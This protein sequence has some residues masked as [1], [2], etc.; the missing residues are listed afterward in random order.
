MLPRF[1]SKPRKIT[2]DNGTAL[3]LASLAGLSFTNGFGDGVATAIDACSAALEHY[4]Q[5]STPLEHADIL[6]DLAFA[7]VT[8]AEVK[9]KEECC[10]TALKIYRRANKI[11]ISAADRLEED[12]D[13]RAALHEHTFPELK[14]YCLKNGAGFRPIDLR[15]GISEEAS[16]DQRT[17]S[18]CLSELRRCQRISPRPNFNL[19]L[20]GFRAGRPMVMAQAREFLRSAGVTGLVLTKMDGTAKGGVILAIVRELVPEA[21]TQERRE[22]AMFRKNLRYFGYEFFLLQLG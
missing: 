15:W 1:H 12:G 7:Y 20:G 19:L 9:D 6:R 18:I 22:F 8:M 21:A 5:E 14:Q 2:A 17:M 13:E 4:S 11:Y 16:L 10:K 3:T